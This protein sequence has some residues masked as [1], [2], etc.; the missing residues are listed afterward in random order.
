[1]IL[2][3]IATAV[4]AGSL[5]TSFGLMTGAMIA[6]VAGAEWLVAVR[7]GGIT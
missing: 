5:V 2:E 1:M 6:I 3:S 7:I 4:G